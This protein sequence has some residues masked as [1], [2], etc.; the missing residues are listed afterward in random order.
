MLGVASIILALIFTLLLLPLI[1]SILNTF[2]WLYGLYVGYQAYNGSNVSIPII[3][4]YV[5]KMGKSEAKTETTT[6]KVK[7]TKEIK[8]E[9]ESLKA[10][11]LRYAKGKITKKEYNKIKK[12]LQA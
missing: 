7:T 3:S 8:Y 6:S 2:I 5:W 10:L 1:S 9:E 12:E 4:N 11:K